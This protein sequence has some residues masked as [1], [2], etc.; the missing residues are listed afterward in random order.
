MKNL[1]KI[2]DAYIQMDER[3]RGEAVLRMVRIAKAHSMKKNP[4][5]RLVVDNTCLGAAKVE[6]C[7]HDLSAT[8]LISS[9]VKG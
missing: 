8:V 3:R 9:I 4:T 6:R 7:H 2:I 1:Q 5:L